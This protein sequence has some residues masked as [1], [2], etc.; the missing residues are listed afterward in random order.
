MNRRASSLQKATDAVERVL[1]FRAEKYK[2]HESYLKDGRPV[3]AHYTAA[4]RHMGHYQMGDMQ[5]HE[6]GEHPLAHAIAQLMMAL[7]LELRD[8]D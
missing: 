2:D 8:A 6:S 4:N 3:S 5:D 1:V 7:E